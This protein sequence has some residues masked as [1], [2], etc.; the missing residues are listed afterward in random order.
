MGLFSKK[1]KSIIVQK[2]ADQKPAQKPGHQESGDEKPA[3]EA[4]SE[5]EQNP[6]DRADPDT[7]QMDRLEASLPKVEDLPQLAKPPTLEAAAVPGPGTPI[8]PVPPQSSLTTP[9]TS[10]PPPT[11]TLATT[12]VLRPAPAAARPAKPPKP[13]KMK[14]RK[15]GVDPADFLALRAELRDMRA[16]LD[17]SEQARAMVESR[18]SS[19]DAAAAAFSTERTDVIEV[20]DMVMQLQQQIAD[21]GG[22]AVSADSGPSLHHD[23]LSAKVD[24]LHNRMFGLQDHS[25]KIAEFEEQIAQLRM[26]LESA[27]AAA[28]EAAAMP[29]PPPMTSGPDPE[30]LERIAAVQLR[31]NDLDQLRHRLG[32]IDHIKQR[33]NEIDDLHQRVAGVETLHQR[34]DELD[35]VEQR[36]GVVDGLAAQL[37]QLNARVAAQAEL[38][39][40]LSALRDRVSQITDQPRDEMDDEMR[41]QMQEVAE[42]LR[43]NDTEARAVRDHMALLDQ[44]LTNVST[45]LANQ[46][47]ELGRDIDGLGQRLPGTA[48]GAVG[49]EIVDALRG[50]QVKLAHEQ[51]RYEIAFR[52]DLATLAELLRQGHENDD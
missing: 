16:R 24:A 21:A 2:P 1:P 11:P 26:E 8:P 34:I 39:G 37:Q 35:N 50:G 22:M 44:R 28:A 14:N 40:Q 38:G 33:M 30:T 32:E 29:P 25:P 20:V 48:E 43:A 19:L 46:L 4:E 12:P 17:E 31:V 9:T 42:R 41:T 18:L 13:P 10:P 49:E 36:L 47:S 15:G 52:Q 7:D 45:E 5:M 23:E 51:A 27:T 6:A 3:D